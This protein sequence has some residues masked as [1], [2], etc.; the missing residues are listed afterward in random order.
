M[1]VLSLH[2]MG[3]P[4][5][6]RE[7]VRALEYMI[8]EC[9]PD[10]NCIVH[11]SDIPFPDYL[12]D[13]DY[14]LIVLGPTFL[15]NRYHPSSLAQVLKSY[16]FIK[17]TRSCKVALPQ[18][19]YDCSGILDDW[20]V[21]WK[22]DRIYTVCPEHWDVLYPKSST[23]AEIKLG[24]TGYIS[25]NWI[26]A[27]HDP[28]SYA[29]RSIDVSY[30]ASKLPANFGSLG[31]LKWE[32]AGRFT[33]AVA[34]HQD[35]KLDISID[36]KDMIAGDAWHAFVEDSKFCLTTA[37]GS[38]LLDPWNEIR[39]CIQHYLAEEPNASFD[40]IET[41]CF[42]GLDQ[43][44]LFTALSPRNIEAALA[45]TVQIATPGT[46]SGLMEPNVHF[47][48]INED[49]SNI[50]DVLKMMRDDSIIVSIQNT[51]KESILSE[52]RLRRDTI[53]EEILSYAES[54]VSNRNIVRSNQELIDSKFKTYNSEKR[55]LEQ[56]HWFKRRFTHKL[57]TK[58]VKYGARHLKQLFKK[59]ISST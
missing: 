31:Q 19:D 10:V 42:K 13:I 57:H 45:K 29:Q 44:Y 3:D 4:R 21:D 52:D 38:S 2:R 14:D 53:V 50:S 18:D 25:K 20:M 58:A 16:D 54:V 49:C 11:D 43:Q 12:K 15:C 23:T 39:M 33:S 59:I 47:I 37:S 40:Q 24:Y 9:R 6:H 1:N 22:I 7:S 28:K 34:N 48:P 32:I 30:R 46:Y 5:F 41:H 8:Q 26:D 17:Q 56:R 55:Q 36:P 51:C 35:I 27:W